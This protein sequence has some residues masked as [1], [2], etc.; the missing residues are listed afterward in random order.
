MPRPRLVLSAALLAACRADPPPAPAVMPGPAPLHRADDAVARNDECVACHAEIADEWQASLHRAAYTA[1]DFQSALRREPLPFCRGCH[2]PE[3]DPRRPQP[4]LAAI[5]V[6]CVSCH[7]PAG[8]AVLSARPDDA[9]QHAAHP[10]LRTASFAAA[11]ACAGCHEF[12]FPDRRPV[13]EYMQT[14]AQELQAS[15]HR[16]TG[17]ADCHMPRVA[18]ANGGSHRSHAFVASR[19]AAWMRSAF[20]VDARRP[21]ADRVELS[22]DLLEDRIGHALPTGDLLRRLVVSVAVDGPDRRGTAQRR[23]LARHWQH[24]RPGEGPSVRTLAH[25]DRLGVGD[26]PRVLQFTLDPADAGLP[27]TWRVRYERVEAF[28]GPGEDG[29]RVVGG[30]DLYMGSLPAFTPSP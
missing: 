2:A 21:A 15:M 13:P 7:L 22:L 1:P 14:T 25:D 29:A 9:P 5:G 10:V 3:A 11:D 20:T 28:V 12:T 23:Y 18:D 16:G 26:D 17:C 4:E 30:L 6:A 8:D 24:A 19:D 27:V